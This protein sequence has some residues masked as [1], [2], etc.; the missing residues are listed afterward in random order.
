MQK[1]AHI[2][3]LLR[4]CYPSFLPWP[5]GGSL[6]TVGGAAEDWAGGGLCLHVPGEPGLQRK[7]Q[8]IVCTKL[9]LGSS[10]SA[11]AARKLLP[12]LRR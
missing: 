4:S 3:A 9:Q 7:G 1:S 2:Q 12:A 8:R 6:E 10:C 11:A 5:Q